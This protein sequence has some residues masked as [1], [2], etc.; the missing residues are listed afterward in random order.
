MNW[1]FLYESLFVVAVSIC[2]LVCKW[3]IKQRVWVTRRWSAKPCRFERGWPPLTLARR[4]WLR[5]RLTWLMN[6]QKHGWKNGF[7]FR[8]ILMSNYDHVLCRIQIFP[9]LGV[10]GLYVPPSRFFFSVFILFS[11]APKMA[12]LIIIDGST[13]ENNFAEWNAS[14]LIFRI[15]SGRNVRHF[16]TA[17]LSEIEVYKLRK[18]D[19]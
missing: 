11:M 16:G 12:R 7:Q 4:R 9:F 13:A 3:P 18:L 10:C 19:C 14:S 5:K 2:Q 6:K 17:Q 8:L 1:S 15:T